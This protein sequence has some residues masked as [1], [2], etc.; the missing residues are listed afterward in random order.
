MSKNFDELFREIVTIMRTDYAGAALTGDRFDPRYYNTAIGQA[1]HD[2]RLDD[3]TFLRYISQMLACTGDHSLQFR[4]LPDENYTPWSPGFFVRRF[5]DSLYVTAVNGDTHLH[6]GDRIIAV[7]R[8]APSRHR[9]AIQKNFFY[10]DTPEREQ[11]HGL[12]KMADSI[13]VLRGEKE[14]VLPIEHH[15]LSAPVCP[16]GLDIDSRGI[17]ILRPGAFDGSGTAA[18]LLESGKAVLAKCKGL[19]ID[20][21]CGCGDTEED[22][23][24]LLPL[25]T[26]S[27]TPADTLLDTEFMALY[28]QRNCSL[29]AAAADDDEFTQYLAAQNHRGFTAESFSSDD[30]IPAGRTVPTAVLADTWC[31]DAAERFVQAAKRANVPVIGRTTLGTIDTAA[32]VNYAMDERFVFTWPTAVT[33]QAHNGNGVMHHGIAPDI[34][35]PWTPEEFLHDVTAETAA[36]YLLGLS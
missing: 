24:P 27:D 1:W 28:T 9:D 29:L 34:P 14:I 6:M 12:L 16:A 5:E 18:H 21:R 19:I 23:Y 2:H 30:M 10:S 32:Q 15:P 22:F 7:N 25:L 20:L 35:V 36:E 8:G 11:W 13:T 33:V 3:L 17:A 31:R 26:V 4:Q